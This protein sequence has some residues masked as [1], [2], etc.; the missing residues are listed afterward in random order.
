MKCCFTGHR[1]N[2]FPWKS[3]NDSRCKKFKERLLQEIEDLIKQGFDY[4]YCGMALGVDLYC[5]E[6]LIALK[7]KYEFSI[8][9]AIPCK[10]QTKYWSLKD[11]FRYKKVLDV[12]SK[13]TILSEHYFPYVMLNRNRYMVDNS[14]LVLAVWDGKAQGGTYFTVNYARE[15]EVKVKII[16][17]NDYSNS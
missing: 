15:K 12:A 10:G 9:C 2:K 4:F 5:A 14:E 11:K 6:C 17:I 3:E 7:D 16:N 1:P 8:E 13:I